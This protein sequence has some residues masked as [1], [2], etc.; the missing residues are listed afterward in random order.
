MHVTELLRGGYALGRGVNQGKG[1][2]AEEEEEE[3]EK[4]RNRISINAK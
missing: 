1:G 3:E 2:G 4:A